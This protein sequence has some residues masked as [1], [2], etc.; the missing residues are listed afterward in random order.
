M[1]IIFK[2]KFKKDLTCRIRQKCLSGFGDELTGPAGFRE[3][4]TGPAG[5]EDG[6][7]TSQGQG[8]GPGPAGYGKA[9]YFGF[10]S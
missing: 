4:H 3:I 1:N 2:T 9:G 5:L 7:Q 6:A 8:I 10:L